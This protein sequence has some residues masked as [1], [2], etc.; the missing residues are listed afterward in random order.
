MFYIYI[1]YSKSADKFYTGYSSDPWRRLVEH[2][3]KPFNSFSSRYRP[4]ELRAVFRCG[5]SA[6]DAMKL[7]KFIK[8]Q[9][10]RNLII[11]LCNPEFQP[12]GIL[13]RL[14]RVPDIR[15]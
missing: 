2:N 14:V 3:T 13:S 9:K 12:A 1:I 8:R 7:E 4:W 5:E 11:R 15:D 10:D 6:G